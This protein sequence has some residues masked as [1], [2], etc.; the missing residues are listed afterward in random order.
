MSYHNWLVEFD[1]HIMTLTLNRPT[2]Q[3]RLSVEVLH[4]LRELA[5]EIEERPD[6]WG[7]VV[8]AAGEHFSVGVDISLIGQ[9]IGQHERNYR[10]NLRDVQDCL[11]KFD[12]IRKPMVAEIH[13]YCLGGGFLL[14]L[15]CDFRI[16]ADS[17]QFGFPEV[18]RSIG[19]I[20]G[21]QRIS[22]LAGIAAAKELTMLGE[23][24]DA[25][26]AAQMGLINSVVPQAALRE[27][28]AAMV[29]KLRQLPPRAVMLNKMII[30]EGYDLP[31]RHSQ[32]LEIDAQ[33][34]L[35]QSPDFQEAIDSF[36][37]KRP[38]HYTGE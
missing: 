34:E 10:R 6:I 13:G 29:S 27:T 8:R 4:E 9:M 18:K 31:L 16:A 2:V 17:S 15:C 35:L 37:E 19:V 32:D 24:I 14:A 25:Q 30:D 20:M 12:S 21:A 1:D 26:R 28:T 23:V 36:Y 5:E 11:D 38:P 22:R 33:F 3:N 7:V